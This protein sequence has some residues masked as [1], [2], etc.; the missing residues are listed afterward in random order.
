MTAENTSTRRRLPVRHNG[1]AVVDSS[2][3]TGLLFAK[4]LDA[5]AAE[6]FLQTW[7]EEPL[8]GCW[9]LCIAVDRTRQVHG[10]PRIDQR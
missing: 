2:L 4:P 6:T 1:R 5:A 7:R 3:A 10:G 9:T 8:V